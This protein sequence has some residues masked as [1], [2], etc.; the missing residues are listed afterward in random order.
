MNRERLIVFIVI[1]G[2]IGYL[3]CTL[4]SYIEV[5]DILKDPKASQNV[6]LL[7]ITNAL[8]GLV[9]GIVAAGFGVEFNPS[10][11]NGLD[12]QTPNHDSPVTPSRM[13]QKF[14]AMGR[15]AAPQ[16][17]EDSRRE[18]LGGLYAWAYIIVGIIGAVLWIYLES[19]YPNVP[20]SVANQATTF[21]GVFIA[22][23]TMYF[24]NS[25]T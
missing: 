18:R 19:E 10:D 14:R 12:N 11:T 16:V 23:I 22:I 21:A 5:F 7:Y 1:A 9:G 8:T 24:S 2:L 15:M 25:N 4:F 6:A 3:G 20:Q 13:Q 17:Q